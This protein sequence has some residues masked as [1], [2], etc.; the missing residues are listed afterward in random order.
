MKS[1]LG[2]FTVW[3]LI[4]TRS[5]IAI[6][7]LTPTILFIGAPHRLITPLWPLHLARAALFALGFSLFYTAFPFMGLAEVTTI[8]F[9]APLMTAALA[10]IFLHETIGRYRIG[11]L[12]LGFIGVL[13]AMNPTGDAL[14]WVGILPLICALSYAISQVIARQIGD[15]ETTLTTGLLTIAFAGVLIVPM[16]YAVNLLL[17]VGQ[18]FRHLRW[19]WQL[20]AADRLYLLVLLGSVGMVGFMLLSRAYQIAHAS[21]I[22]PFDYTY[23]PFATAMAFVPD[24]DTCTDISGSIGIL[25]G[26]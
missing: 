20:P 16:G 10:A 26:R 8:F 18:D 9:A 7:L 24:F 1:L 17:D 6:V 12:A 3:M 25:K 2:E 14:Q 15:R 19:D 5:I 21:L 23:L 4:L 13:I 22:A 11:A